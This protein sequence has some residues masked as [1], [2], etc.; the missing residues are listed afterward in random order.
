VPDD[1]QDQVGVELKKLSNHGIILLYN[2]LLKMLGDY[3]TLH[4]SNAYH[5]GCSSSSIIWSFLALT[6]ACYL[7]DLATLF[8][9]NVGDRQELKSVEPVK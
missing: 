8:F 1:I 9:E 2:S 3:I 5:A 6:V 4:H 7:T